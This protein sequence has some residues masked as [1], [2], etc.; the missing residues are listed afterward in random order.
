MQNAAILIVGVEEEEKR[1]AVVL[2]FIARVLRVLNSE[3]APSQISLALCLGMAAG[4]T[5]LLSPHN[6]FILFLA[7]LLRVNLSTFIVAFFFFTG[8]AYLLDPLFHALGLGVLTASTMQ[9]LWGALYASTFWRA[10]NFNNTIVMGSVLVCLAAFPPLFFLSNF[11][12]NKYREHILKW[13]EKSRLMQLFKGSRLY[14]LYRAF[15]EPGGA[16]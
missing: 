7:L 8:T 11:M 6:L 15:G 9:G 1:G 5:P 10:L 13:V 12:I 2:K 16:P 14:R 3:A 4:L